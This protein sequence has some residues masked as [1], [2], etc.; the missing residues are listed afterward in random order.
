MIRVSILMIALALPIAARAQGTEG[1]SVFFDAV[2]FAAVGDSTRIDIY[3]AV[4]YNA[5]TYDRSSGVFTAHYQAQIKVEG[6]GRVAYDSIFSR[7]LRAGTYDLTTGETPRYEF[8]QRRVVVPPG[9]YAVT[10]D[11]LD[12]HTNL[13]TTLKR[14]VTAPT[15]GE[16]PLVLSGLLLVKKIREDSAGSYVITPLISEAVPSSSDAFFI[17][18]EAYNNRAD[19]ECVVTATCRDARRQVV[20]PVVVR[21]RLPA[22]RSQQWVRIPTEGMPRGT[23]TV[24]VKATDPNDS[25]R[26][27]ASAARPIRTEGAGAGVP[28]A[29]E[30]LNQRILQLRYVTTQTEIDNIRGASTLLD[31]Q[32]RYLDLWTRLDPT[33]GTAANEAMDE[34]FRRIDYADENF[35]SYA[36]GWLTDKGRVYV[37]YGPP[38]NIATDP[39]RSDGKAVETW[40]Y[41]RRN[42]RLVFLDDSGFG[43]FRLTT[44]MPLGEKF[45]YGS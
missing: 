33:P 4:P 31:R 41:Y 28:L 13:H 8:Y 45:R 40:Q 44:P 29:E 20:P 23:F 42:L 39:F 18:F 21:K 35:R 34:Y 30:E 37:I 25:S 38:D 9:I 2:P 10:A 6:S 27:F 12:V 26:V 22:G 32:R 36:A 5:V 43:D 15:Y 1:T 3:L 7:T 24:E 16:A 17:F 14:S 11:V 19:T